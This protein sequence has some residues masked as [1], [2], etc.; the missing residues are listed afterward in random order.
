M[1]NYYGSKLRL[2]KTYPEPEHNLIIEPFA[3]SAQYAVWWLE[4]KPEATA[5]VYDIDPLVVASWNRI[6]KASPSEILSWKITHGDPIRDYIDLANRAGGM[7]PR[8]TGRT[9]QEFKAS[10]VRWAKQR[11]AVGNRIECRVGDYRDVKNVSATWFIDPPYQHQ[12]HAYDYGSKQIDYSSLAEWCKERV[13]QAIVCEAYPADWL[14]FRKHKL[15]QT[16][17]FKK[18]I[19]MVWTHSSDTRNR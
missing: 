4:R 16:Q 1:F 18:S 5:I 15:L 10:K 6:M 8:A 19:E 2:A 3:G 13:G 12:G 7:R 9:P 11:A 17:K 14:P